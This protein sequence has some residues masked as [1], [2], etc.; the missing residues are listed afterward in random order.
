MHALRVCLFLLAAWIIPSSLHA[1]TR[2]TTRRLTA[3]PAAFHRANATVIHHLAF[4][5]HFPPALDL[6]AEP[7]QSSVNPPSPSHAF[8]L[9]SF[10]IHSVL[11]LFRHP[12][13]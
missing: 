3:S 5:Y 13:A 8:S 6:P 4:P 10:A 9:I 2:L 11:G 1:S 12:P 7:L